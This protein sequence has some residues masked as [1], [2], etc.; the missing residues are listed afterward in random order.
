LLKTASA[1][2][3]A[4]RVLPSY[5]GHGPLL[6]GKRKGSGEEGSVESKIGKEK[7]EMQGGTRNRQRG[8]A[9]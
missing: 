3:V 2:K 6:G 8:G 7:N 1:I 4:K 9:S 5:L